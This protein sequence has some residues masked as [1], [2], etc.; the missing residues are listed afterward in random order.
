MR[1]AG[2]VLLACLC[3]FLPDE[4]TAQSVLVPYGTSGYRYSISTSSFPPGVEL[5]SFDDSGFSVSGST[6][7]AAKLAEGLN[8]NEWSRGSNGDEVR[9]GHRGNEVKLGSRGRASSAE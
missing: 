3:V 9:A 1:N 2:L 6:S 5:P 7:D 4:A 8:E